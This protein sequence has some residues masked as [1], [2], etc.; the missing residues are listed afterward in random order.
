MGPD[1]TAAAQVGSGFYHALG[2]LAYAN[3]LIW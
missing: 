1:I 2:H 3:W